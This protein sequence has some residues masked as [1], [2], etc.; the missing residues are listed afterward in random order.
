MWQEVEK[1]KKVS[2]RGKRQSECGVRD[3]TL[4]QKGNLGEEVYFLYINPS[5]Q[6]SSLAIGKTC[7]ADPGVN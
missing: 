7:A 5:H 6:A 3:E 2:V 1:G 4:R